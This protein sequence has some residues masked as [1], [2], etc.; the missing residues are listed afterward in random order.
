MTTSKM[1]IYTVFCVL[2]LGSLFSFLSEGKMLYAY[3]EDQEHSVPIS[4]EWITLPYSIA[5]TASFVYLML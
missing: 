4:P 2:Q 3:T 1:G 5:W